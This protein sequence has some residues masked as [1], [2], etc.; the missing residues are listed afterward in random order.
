[1]VYRSEKDTKVVKF[2]I[3]ELLDIAIKSS[4]KIKDTKGNDAFIHGDITPTE[5]NDGREGL[6]T[7]CFQ[8]IEAYDEFAAAYISKTATDSNYDHIK[9]LSLDGLS[10]SDLSF[11]RNNGAWQ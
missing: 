6:K 4:V 7:D 5:N 10:D 11:M 2:S 8:I 1:M 3:K 9:I